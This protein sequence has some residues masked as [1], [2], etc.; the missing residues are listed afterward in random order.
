MANKNKSN[1][2]FMAFPSK[3]LFDSHCHLDSIP[4]YIKPQIEAAITAGVST[5]VTLGTDIESS[6]KGLNIQHKYPEVVMAGIGIQ[7]EL[8]IPG[9]EMFNETID[10]ENVFA[11]IQA[12]QDTLVKNDFKL[13]GECGLDYYWLTK[14]KALTSMQIEKSMYLQKYLFQEQ[15]K[16]AKLFNLPVSLHSRAAENDCIEM[17]KPYANT[18]PI[19]F[20]SFTGSLEQAREILS[21]GFK[22]GINGIITYKSAQTLR[23]NLVTLLADKNIA[24]IADLYEAGFF[25]ETDSPLLKPGNSKLTDSFNSPK[26]LPYIWDF[27]TNLLNL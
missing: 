9:G 14:N 11:L 7:P 23:D 25:L 5:M 10:Q 17:C 19:I 26:Q 3:R 4:G 27:V 2:P 22:I 6:L 18:M 1:N 21:M 16:L 20:H 12:F 8:V 24:T 15:L 13:I